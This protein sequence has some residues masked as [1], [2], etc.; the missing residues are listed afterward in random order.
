MSAEGE[1]LGQFIPVQVEK[2][3]DAQI[4]ILQNYQ[5][6]NSQM[7]DRL[8]R[9]ELYQLEPVENLTSTSYL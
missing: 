3:L 8:R 7:H 6:K 2:V 4:E 5:Q 1:I 9:I